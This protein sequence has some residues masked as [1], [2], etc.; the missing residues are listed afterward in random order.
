MARFKHIT[1]LGNVQFT[2]EEESLRDA[3]EAQAE[4]DRQEYL[5]VKYKDDRK[6]DYPSY[7]DQLDTIYHQGIDAWKAEI[8]AVKAKYPKPE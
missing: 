2:Q 8:K 3:E 1:G 7:A 4:L 5:K 6:M